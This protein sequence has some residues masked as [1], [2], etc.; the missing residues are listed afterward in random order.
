MYIGV[1]NKSVRIA[2][3]LLG[4]KS[5][6]S[7]ERTKTASSVERTDHG[8][9]V[10]PSRLSILAR[11]LLRESIRRKCEISNFRAGNGDETK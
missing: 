1:E 6:F 2:I 3:F 11:I 5:F 4:E 10:P 7:L 8:P 9:A